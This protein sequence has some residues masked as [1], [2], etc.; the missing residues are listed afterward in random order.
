MMEL[1]SISSHHGRQG[2]PVSVIV[3]PCPPFSSSSM[4]D[5]QTSYGLEEVTRISKVYKMIVVLLCTECHYLEFPGCSKHDEE[6]LSVL[7][8]DGHG[9]CAHCS[10]STDFI[11]YRS[12]PGCRICH[13]PTNKFLWA[14]TVT[15]ARSLFLAFPPSSLLSDSDTCEMNVLHCPQ[16]HVVKFPVVGGGT[17]HL[18]LCTKTTSGPFT[19]WGTG[20]SLHS[21]TWYES[22]KHVAC[23][24]MIGKPLEEVLASIPYDE[25]EY[26][27]DNV[28]K[29][30]T[31]KKYVVPAKRLG[32]GTLIGL[33]DEEG[34]VHGMLADMATDTLLEVMVMAERYGFMVLCHQI[35]VAVEKRHKPK[36]ADVEDGA[37]SIRHL[38]GLLRPDT[39]VSDGSQ[40]H[41][42]LSVLLSITWS[43]ADGL[44][45]LLLW[46][47]S[48]LDDSYHGPTRA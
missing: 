45:V 27:Y 18:S 46:W 44:S 33:G 19:V 5:G 2:M 15:E 23:C 17:L 16:C 25:A 34:L 47:L 7:T 39:K 40:V 26:L 9:K 38:W 1:L 10:C 13:K 20:E 11:P 24:P 3:D 37:K 41:R 29:G 4:E 31:Y 32:V 42:H 30:Q 35:M 48:G 14:I 6:L 22:F 36:L 43:T 21:S 12:K 8:P 28:A